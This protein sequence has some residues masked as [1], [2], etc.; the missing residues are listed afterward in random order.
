[1]TTGKVLVAAAVHTP[2]G[3]VAY[4]VGNVAPGGRS[5]K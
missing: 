3:F 1:L 4:D 5:P 2:R